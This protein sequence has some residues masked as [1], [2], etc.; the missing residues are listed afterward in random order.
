MNGFGPQADDH[1]DGRHAAGDTDR[2]CGAE[3]RDI[4]PD[5][6]DRGERLPKSL[7]DPPDQAQVWPWE[8]TGPGRS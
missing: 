8:E 5:H 7:D 3:R 4:Q 6:A 1:Q 2:V